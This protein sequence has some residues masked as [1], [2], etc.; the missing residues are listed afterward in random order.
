[1]FS[2]AIDYIFMATWR[3]EAKNSA[4]TGVSGTLVAADRHTALEILRGQGLFLTL[5]EAA[6]VRKEQ[7]Q[8]ATPPRANIV[9]TA[10]GATN[11][12]ASP[13]TPKN[14]AAK[15]VSGVYRGGSGGTD[16][17]GAPTYSDPRT[18]AAA[19][20]AAPRNQ[21]GLPPL[22]GQPLLHASKRDLSN[23]FSQLAA[24]AHAGVTLG[25][26]LATL[27]EHGPHPALRSVASQLKERVMSGEPISEGM[28][29]FPGLFTPLMIG[30]VSAGERGGFIERSFNRLAEYS[31][32]DYELE[33]AIKRETW[34]PKLLIFAAILIPGVV[35]LVLQGVG[36]FFRQVL[37]PLILIGLI[38]G[39][40]K[41]I[42]IVRPAL[43]MLNPLFHFWD[44]VKLSLPIIGKITRGLA[45]AKFCRALGALYAAGVTPSQ[46][47]R[48]GAIACGN[49]VMHDRCM[50]IIPRLEQGETLTQ[51]LGSLKVFHP[52]ALQMLQVGEDS[53]DIDS[54]LEKAADFLER[55]SET[56]IRQA[57]PALGILVF[58][59]V[60]A[61]IGSMVISYYTGTYGAEINNLIDSQ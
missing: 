19:F 14:V 3:Y 9:S 15:P 25:K 29:A 31:E 37:P 39:A 36:P 58:L 12:N 38:W 7:A 46:S 52:M 30:V 50:A 41:A 32:R 60:A 4:G 56:A 21:A 35:P 20:N 27:Q 8:P 49:Q 47:V 42:S 28:K 24:S 2:G 22:K 16:S 54:Q 57:I 48:F 53:G 59:A 23:F 18:S 44:G 40:F 6:P 17:T 10:Q 13:P 5:L 55:D 51:A 43:T 61:Y 1:L 33:T 26:A 34:Y 45:T 11:S